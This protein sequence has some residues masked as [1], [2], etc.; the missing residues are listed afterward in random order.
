M[1][2][3]VALIG[4]GRVA[5]RGWGDLPLE[6]HMTGI[7]SC[8]NT[9]LSAAADTDEEARAGFAAVHSGVPVFRDAI[10]AAEVADI[11][12][13]CTPPDT[14]AAILERICTVPTVRAII[15]EKPLATSVAEAAEMVRMAG[16]RVLVTAHQRRYEAG[17]RSATRFVDGGAIG[18]IMAAQGFFSGDYLNNGTHAADLCRMMVG[19]ERPWSIKQNGG[20]FGIVVVGDRGSLTLE[21]YGKLSPGYMRT[22]YEDVVGCLRDPGRKPLCTGEDGVEAVRH[23]LYAQER[24][25]SV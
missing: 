22:M 2:F 7:E 16:N 25:A 19:D 8:A 13:I 15:C 17:H 5:W 9:W 24:D 12:T 3:R 1:M 18:H 6:T 20:G 14:H 4:L 23:A 11:V 21:S 10:H